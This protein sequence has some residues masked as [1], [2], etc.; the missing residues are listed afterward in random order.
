MD[1]QT[2]VAKVIDASKLDEEMTYLL[3]N[4][5]TIWAR[6]AHPHIV[7]FFGMAS[8]PTAVL[9][10]CEMLPAGAL[11]DHLK[12]LREKHAPPP[13]EVDLV[14]M[15]QQIATGME[16]LHSLDVLHRDLKSAVRTT[17][18]RTF[19]DVPHLPNVRSVRSV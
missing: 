5:C 4:E 1:G 17:S 12:R 6:L 8:T 7:S 3:T 11:S 9:L 13:K 16:Y 15:L 10:V 19:V 18:D 2:A 14:M